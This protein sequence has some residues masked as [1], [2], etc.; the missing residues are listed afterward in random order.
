[1]PTAQGAKEIIE[2][3]PYVTI[4]S[5]SEDGQP[6]NAPVFSAYD[7]DYNF[8]WGSHK[9]SQHSRNIRFNKNIFLVIY[10][11][12]VPAGKGEGVYI[13]A[14]A[15]ELEDAAEIGSAHR[16][17]TVRHV[18]PYWKLEQ[19]RG[20]GPIRLYKAAPEKVW[21]NGEGE[22]DGHYVDVRVEIQ[23]PHNI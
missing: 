22:A 9:D 14:A 19:V 20:S 18:A 10:D 13:R 4:A 23:L 11:S 21:M 15:K 2:K 6:W 8:Y 3:I 7:K 16:L 5:I 12:T 1:M 17:L